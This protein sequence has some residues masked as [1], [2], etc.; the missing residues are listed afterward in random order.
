MNIGIV[1]PL[2]SKQISKNWLITS[3]AL[4]ATLNSILQQSVNKYEVVVCG[5]D[6][7][8]FLEA[9][10]YES[11]SFVSTIIPAPDR[12]LPNFS[13]RDLI[14]DK[15]IKIAMGVKFIKPRNIDYWYQLDSDDLLHRDFVKIVQKIDG[16]AGAIIEGGYILYSALNRAIPTDEMSQYCGSTSILADQYVSVPE[17]FNEESIKQLPWA[18][19]PHM[20][21]HDFFKQE[22]KQPFDV[23]HEK[24]LGYVLAT[25]DNISDKWRDSPIKALKAYLKPLIKGHK[26]STEIMDQFSMLD[27]NNNNKH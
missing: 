7:P 24:V 2:K 21:M 16:K 12:S 26:I 18:N 3:Q 17:Q 13:H 19:Y 15:N 27:C 8:D 14:I 11:I 9:P 10:P 4:Q 5:H 22:L 6:K 23:I 25:G 20:A 1:I